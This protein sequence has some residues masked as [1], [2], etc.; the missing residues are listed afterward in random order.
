MLPAKQRKK[1]RQKEGK[2][3]NSNTLCALWQYDE[4]E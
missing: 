3:K 1:W 2:S 4:K